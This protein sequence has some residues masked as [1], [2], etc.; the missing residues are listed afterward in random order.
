MSQRL[1][2]MI[3]LIILFTLVAC[4]A[5][6]PTPAATQ[7]PEQPTEAPSTP[8]QAPPTPTTAPT[9]APCCAART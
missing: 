7:P 8:T 3:S 6:A 1:F 9:A 5:P 2:W 4:Q